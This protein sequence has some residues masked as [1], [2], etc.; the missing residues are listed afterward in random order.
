MKTVIKTGWR[1]AWGQPEIKG[2]KKAIEG[3]TQTQKRKRR[4]LIHSYSFIFMHVLILL[5]NLIHPH[6]NGFG[7]FRVLGVFYF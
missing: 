3:S 7:N 2:N 1:K 6:G 4:E 5:Q